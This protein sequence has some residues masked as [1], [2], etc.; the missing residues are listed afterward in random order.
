M[1]DRYAPHPATL[2]RARAAQP[3]LATEA[4]TPHPATLPRARAT[5]PKMASDARPLHSAAQG[6]KAGAARERVAQ[7]TNSNPFSALLE[8]N[9]DNEL[10]KKA[11]KK[12]GKEQLLEQE[13]RK[14]A[15]QRK[16]KKQR[17]NNEAA[18]KQQQKAKQQKREAS[19]K[20]QQQQRKIER[21]EDATNYEETE[22][23]NYSNDLALKN[24]CEVYAGAH[25][26]EA[27]LEPNVKFTAAVSMK[28]G[29]VMLRP[30]GVLT[31]KG[32]QALVPAFAERIA[33]VK[34][35]ESWPTHVCSEV[36]AMAALLNA[37]PRLNTTEIKYYTLC[38][39]RGDTE[40]AAP[41]KNCKQWMDGPVVAE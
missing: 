2:P 32:L 23:I 18:A 29:K 7:P 9:N 6:Q 1:T 20:R 12:L 4:R 3:R 41:C 17:E 25:L 21:V 40:Y 33:A 22:Q 13:Q 27:A 24:A 10:T 26:K 36:Y 30:S 15:R 34:R 28:T 37:E 5:Q 14:A 19:A 8:V 38:R 39:A 31:L 16:K 11:K 35:I